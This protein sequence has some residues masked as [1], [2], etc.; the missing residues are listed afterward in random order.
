[1][2]ESCHSSQVATI[3]LGNDQ[4]FENYRSLYPR[5][6]SIQGSIVQ[7]LQVKRASATS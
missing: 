4:K 5:Y 3:A 6:T 7:T 1:M 2:A